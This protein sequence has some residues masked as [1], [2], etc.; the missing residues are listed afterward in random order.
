MDFDVMTRSEI[1]SMVGSDIRDTA[2]RKT[3]RRRQAIAKR[4]AFNANA[5]ISY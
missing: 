1:T 2:G 3:S 4:Y 5:M